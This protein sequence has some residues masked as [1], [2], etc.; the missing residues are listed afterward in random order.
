LPKI[1]ESTHFS[2]QEIAPGVYAAI[3]TRA[4]FGVSNAAI[5]DLGGETLVL[6]TMNSMAAGADLRQAAE[7][8]FG[9]PVGRLVISH[10]HGD[11]WKGNG[12]FGPET[13]ILSSA[14]TKADLG[15]QA[16]QVRAYQVDPS[17]Y[18]DVL[19]GYRE[20][21]EMEE[22]ARWRAGLEWSIARIEHELAE[23]PDFVMRLPNEIF[24]G[25]QVFEGS[26][27][28]VE[29]V[30]V[31]AVHSKDDCYLV[32]PEDGV[33]FLADLGFFKELPVMRDCDVD[34]WRAQLDSLLESEH[35]LLVPGHGLVGGKAEL[36]EQR[37]Y[38]DHLEEKVRQALAQ[39]GEEAAKA[40]EPG[41]PYDGWLT[42]QMGRLEGDVAYFMDYLKDKQTL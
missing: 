10:P 26:Q 13:R 17:I 2:L 29:L 34:A 37:G 1:P 40:V 19:R 23:L 42:G 35:E 22:D 27:R 20:R 21:L 18:D 36:A 31:G 15:S 3:G 25:A 39:T 7:A 32:L 6:D 9:R 16:K 5:I 4:G 28:R 41:P 24:E 8:L 30:H 14:A 38:L 11:H 12:A 33:I